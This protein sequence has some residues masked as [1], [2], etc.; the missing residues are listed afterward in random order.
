MRRQ[1]EA[2][3]RE[4]LAAGP[5]PGAG[6]PAEGAI[7]ALHEL[8][9]HPLEL[10]MQNDE[11]ARTLAEAEAARARFS[12]F[13][14]LSP[15]GFC[16]L[17][18]DGLVLEANRRLAG[19]LAAAP[20]HLIGRPLLG[21]VAVADRD[22]FSRQLQPVFAGA[23]PQACDLTLVPTGGP[24]FRA[25]LAG[26]AVQSQ[27]G[28]PVCRMVV[29]DISERWAAEAEVRRLAAG[30]ELR[31]QERTAQ[32]Q[33]ANQELEAFS[34]SVSHDLRAPLRTIDGFGRVL[35]EDHLEQ[36][37]PEGRACVARIRKGARSMAG[38]IDALLTL[39]RTVRGD[40]APS[41]CDLSA[42][43]ARAAAELAERSP[44]R[45]VAVAIQPGMRVLA[46]PGLL[47]AALGN[48][49]DNAFKFTGRCADPRVA[50]GEQ[51]G[52]GG[53]RTFW[54]RDNGAGFDPA[55]AARLFAPFQRLH[56]ASDFPGTGIGLASVQRIIH[57]HGG[58]I[59]A[60]GEPGQGATFWFTLP[61]PAGRCALA[62]R[63]P[64]EGSNQA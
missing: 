13:Y 43:W 34:Y 53:E 41:V 3:L 22:R 51:P 16:S 50:V 8:S 19:M 27:A 20:E 23:G 46:D 62:K 63:H 55:Q 33:A 7:R 28:A 48:L 38:L 36:L 1:A 60:H 30:L 9:V 10:E 15:A 4:R 14:E 21:F 61:D 32:L 31:V 49:L 59:W 2:L 47:Q 6:G 18:R 40:L 37:D 29:S 58:R 56:P 35:E 24:P 39:A 26:I 17:D 57:R 12:D 25:H 42:A 5:G 11:L 64:G 44:E 52:P 54:V 45:R